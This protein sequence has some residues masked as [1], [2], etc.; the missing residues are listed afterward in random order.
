MCSSFAGEDETAS[1]TR[2]GSSSAR[3]AARQR[4]PAR[5]RVEDEEADLVLWNVDRA[6]EADAASA[7][8]RPSVPAARGPRA[9]PRGR[10]RGR[11]RRGS[12]ACPRRYGGRA[13]DEN[14]RTSELC[15]GAQ[16]GARGRARCASGPRAWRRCASGGSRPCARRGRAQRRPRGSSGPRRRVRRRA[17][18]P[19]SAP[20]HAF[21]RRCFRAPTWLARSRSRAPS[22]SNPASA[23]AIA[24]RA[25]RFCRARRRSTPSARSA[26]ARP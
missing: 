4:V 23:S 24:S 11:S 3:S 16:S 19:G 17:A 21:G 7:R 22:C 10:G 14:V 20:P 1:T 26:R 13:A 2:I 5:R 12:S 18:R 9:R 15:S 6:V 25:G 8:P